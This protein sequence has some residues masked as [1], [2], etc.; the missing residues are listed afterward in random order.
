M[1]DLPD[2][3]DPFTILEQFTIDRYEENQFADEEE[4]LLVAAVEERYEQSRASKENRTQLVEQ[5]YLLLKGGNRIGRTRVSNETLRIITDND[6]RKGKSTDNIIIDKHRAFVGKFTRAVPMVR[7]RARSSDKEDLTAAELMDSKLDAFR[8]GQ[9]IRLRYKRWIE[10]ISPAGTGIMQIYWDPQKGPILA[11]CNVCKFASRDE[12]PGDPCPQCAQAIEQQVMEQAQQ[13]SEEAMVTAE[14]PTEEPE[15]PEVPTLK[16]AREGD[17]C[18]RLVQFRDFFPDPGATADPETVNWTVTTDAIHVSKLRR[19]F[20]EKADLIEEQEGLYRDRY[21]F[22]PTGLAGARVETRELKSHA[23]LKTYYEGPSGLHEDGRVIYICNDRLLGIRPYVEARLLGR[24]AF[25]YAR[26]DI[27]E[28]TLWGMDI[29]SQA[30]PQQ[31]ERDTLVTQLRRWRELGLNQ[32]WLVSSM[33]GIHNKRISTVPGAIIKASRIDENSIRPL[34]V[35]QIPAYVPGEL[36]RLD[37]AAQRKFGVTSHELGIGDPGESGRYAAF[38]ETQASETVGPMAIEV[39]DEF[40]E[41]HRAAIVISRYYESKER[42]WTT[43]SKGRVFSH[44]WSKANVLPGWDVYLVNVDSISRNPVLREQAA[45]ERFQMG[46][47]TDQSTGRVDWDKFRLDA[48]LDHDISGSDSEASQHIKAAELPRMIEEALTN[49]QPPPRPMP[50]DN[51]FIIASGL[52]DW[53]RGPGDMAMEPVRRAVAMIWFE[54]CMALQP[55]EG[56]PMDPETAKIMPN[57]QLWKNYANPQPAGPG[58]GGSVPGQ[59]K[60]SSKPGAGAQRGTPT[61]Q[62]ETAQKTRAADQ[63]AERAARQT[64]RQ[65]S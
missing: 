37:E 12:T 58:A 43:T 59:Q 47:Y 10:A 19:M 36:N 18:C 31:R 52:A 23:Q 15:V 57:A 38:L 8:L 49:G 33:A 13:A 4:A 34:K 48:G 46:Y 54:Y 40:L 61:A 51:P 63:S 35:Q 53:L 14:M 16:E 3:K 5:N 41:A 1:Y 11:T 21:I 62:Q 65:E 24:L 39:N 29:I 7:A 27:D 28:D 55:P 22:A 25:Y 26:G 44:S 9:K 20:P 32:Q 50:W 2:T 56:V 6:P 60:G 17:C 30:E 42:I 64:S 45:K